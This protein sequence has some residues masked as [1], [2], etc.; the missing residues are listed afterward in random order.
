[1]CCN[2]DWDLKNIPVV[3]SFKRFGLFMLTGGEPMLHP[4]QVIKTILRIKSQSSAPII[5]YTARVQK[6]IDILF[7]LDGLTLTLHEQKDVADFKKFNRVLRKHPEYKN[8]SLRLNVFAEVNL[9]G[10][11]DLS[12]WKIKDN[13]RWIKDCPLPNDEV[14]MRLN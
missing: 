13:I 14:F 7:F 10:V 9:D 5:L 2:K 8:K 4:D 3:K 11:K 6:L 12:N 1:M